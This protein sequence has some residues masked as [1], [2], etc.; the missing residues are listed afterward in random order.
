MYKFKE[1]K[2]FLKWAGGKTQ[3]IDQLTMKMPKRY[4][5]YYEPFVGGGAL[6]FYI[7]PQYG[8]INDINKALINCY[9]VIRDDY[10]KLIQ[11]INKLDGGEINDSYYNSIRD[12]YN[13]HLR[14]DYYNLETA[15]LMIWLNKHCFNGL[16]RVNYNG[17]FN[18]P[19]N[20]Y[21]GKSIDNENIINVGRY[22]KKVHISNL[23]FEQFLSDCSKGDFVYMDPP[24]IPEVENGFTSYNQKEFGNEEHIR[25]AK[26]FK[27]LTNKGVYCIVSNSNTEMSRELY[28]DY[29]IDVVEA[30]RNINSKGDR[31]STSELIITNY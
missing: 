22:L 13:Y 2:P 21:K 23:D 17:E 8:Y 31:R 9:T 16:Y 26:V 11:Y 10:S 27:E 15:G 12:M 30:K 1:T 7:K 5:R 19:W 29:K 3:L 6:F 25:L 4:G 14:N 18:V 28:R 20:T 24:Y